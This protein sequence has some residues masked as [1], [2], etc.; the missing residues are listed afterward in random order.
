V[1][2][3]ATVLRDG[4]ELEFGAASDPISWSCS[5]SYPNELFQFRNV[6]LVGMG[7]RR[8]LQPLPVVGP[9]SAHWIGPSCTPHRW[10]V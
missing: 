9:R 6:R 7:A 10:S 8:Q 1:W 5:N 4:P 2:T 3:V